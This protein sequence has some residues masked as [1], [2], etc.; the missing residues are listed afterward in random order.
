MSDRSYQVELLGDQAGRLDLIIDGR[1]IVACVSE[2]SRGHWV[3]VNGRTFHLNRPAAPV[4]STAAHRGQSE[5]VAPMPGQV[6]TV[7]VGAGDIVTKGQLLLVLEAMK[8]EIRLSAP[9]D[10]Q[11]VSVEAHVGQ[12]VE[13]EQILARL[14]PR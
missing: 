10:A 2:E 6:R 5:L 14:Q 3:T 12:T 13:R 11:V 8:M 1:R 7:E 4:R 9:F